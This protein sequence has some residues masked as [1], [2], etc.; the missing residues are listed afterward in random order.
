MTSPDLNIDLELLPDL[1]LGPD[2]GLRPTVPPARGRRPAPL[3]AVVSR[4]LTGEDV[5]NLGTADWGSAPPSIQKLKH[6]HHNLARLL[7]QGLPGSEVSLIT[8][9]S[10]SRISILQHD[11][12]F[13]EL[14]VY[15]VEQVEEVFV[16]VH[17]R[18]ATVGMDALQELQDRLESEGEDFSVKELLDTIGITLDRGGYGPKSIVQHDLSGGVHELL[19]V[20][21]KEV[22]SRQ[23][24]NI[25]TL[26]TRQ[27]PSADHRTPV[28]RTLE[29]EA[30]NDTKGP[31]E[32]N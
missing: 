4:P 5:L 32:G 1:G 22:D 2:L 30:N 20:I 13:A 27:A 12:A 8:G 3:S 29:L 11:P 15:Y 25:K 18:L 23:N 19:E 31:R 26:V 21:K 10:P 24:G 6:S 28:G 9:Y 7:A 14:M 16:N 17:E